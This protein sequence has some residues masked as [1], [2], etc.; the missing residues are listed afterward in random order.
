MGQNGC[1]GKYTF[2]NNENEKLDLWSPNKLYTLTY[3]VVGNK[4]TF[5]GYWWNGKEIREKKKQYSADISG[6]PGSYILT[7][8]N[9]AVYTQ[10]NADDT[11][12]LLEGEEGEAKEEEE[13]EEREEAEEGEEEK[14]EEGEF[15]LFSFRSPL[16]EGEEGE[17][18]KEEAMTNNQ[19][20]AILDG[21]YVVTNS[22]MTKLGQ[23][24]PFLSRMVARVNTHSS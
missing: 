8:S 14:E 22:L 19:A 16:Q 4:L 6:S 23:K 2:F 10:K 13:G 20:C 15:R 12:V 11:A 1:S 7:W 9:K 21:K 24:L 5:Y 17:E 18:E 3:R